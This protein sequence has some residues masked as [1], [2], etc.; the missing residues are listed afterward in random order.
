MENFEFLRIK[1]LQQQ[2][3]DI[4]ALRQSKQISYK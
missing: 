3:E 4:E 2:N 1:M